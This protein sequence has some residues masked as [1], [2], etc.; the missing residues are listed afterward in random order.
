MVIPVLIPK[1]RLRPLVLRHPILLGRQS[2]A[3]FHIIVFHNHHPGSNWNPYCHPAPG[4]IHGYAAYTSPT[5]YPN[6]LIRTL[7]PLEM[8]GSRAVLFSDSRNVG[9]DPFAHATPAS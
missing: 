4:R 3:Q 9:G 5:R 6:K 8:T 7:T 2:L 1:R